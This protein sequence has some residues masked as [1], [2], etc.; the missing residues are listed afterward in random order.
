MKEQESIPS[1][2]G[3]TVFNLWFAEVVDT[4]GF[5]CILAGI[6]LEGLEDA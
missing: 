4:V 5:L 3:S 2:F 1:V 6:S